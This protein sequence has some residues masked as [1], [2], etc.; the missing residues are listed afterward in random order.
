M[1]NHW[2]SHCTSLFPSQLF[3]SATGDLSLLSFLPLQRLEPAFPASRSP[4]YSPHLPTIQ[5][6]SFLLLHPHTHHFALQRAPSKGPPS[7]KSSQKI[8]KDKTLPAQQLTFSC[9]VFV[10]FLFPQRSNLFT[11]KGQCLLL[12]ILVVHG[13]RVLG[14]GD[15]SC[16]TLHM[17]GSFMRALW[18]SEH[19]RRH[20]RDIDTV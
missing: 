2:S 18:L 5:H 19:H 9:C 14:E 4:L 10:M 13:G 1:K 3:S 6:S 15:Y 20:L 17:E 11:G 16:H 8:V 7:F 12:V